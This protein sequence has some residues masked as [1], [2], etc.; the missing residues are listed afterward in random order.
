V[1]KQ[2][3]NFGDSMQ[4]ILKWVSL[5]EWAVRLYMSKQ[6]QDGRQS[7]TR[8]GMGRGDM[9]LGDPGTERA[10]EEAP[11]GFQRIDAELTHIVPAAIAVAAGGVA[12]GSV[13]PIG[14]VAIVGAIAGAIVGAIA[15]HRLLRNELYKKGAV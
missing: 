9:A 5:S 14:G 7:K 15:G 8:V 13:V 10:S 2:R 12:I 4:S 3:I 1:T 6:P 11:R